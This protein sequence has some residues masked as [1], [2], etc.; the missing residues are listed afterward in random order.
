MSFRANV[1]RGARGSD[2]RESGF[3]RPGGSLAGRRWSNTC[4]VPTRGGCFRAA[5][6]LSGRNCCGYERQLRTL[7][8][9]PGR[10]SARPLF[11]NTRERLWLWNFELPLRV[12]AALP[13]AAIGQSTF[14]FTLPARDPGLRG[15][16]TRASDNEKQ[17]PWTQVVSGPFLFGQ[18]QIRRAR[19]CPSDGGNQR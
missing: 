8:R 15:L 5:D 9:G 17:R 6:G 11:K 2:W 13:T 19:A 1:A 4:V 16:S 14:G 18:D 12:P 10:F 3:R 7:R